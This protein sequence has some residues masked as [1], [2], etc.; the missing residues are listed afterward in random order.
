MP[1]E[2]FC[3]VLALLDQPDDAEALGEEAICT[4]RRCPARQVLASSLT[5]AAEAAIIADRLDRADLILREL[6]VLLRE[7]G[8][9][10]WVAEALELT[11]L[12]I[13]ASDPAA[14]A[15]ALGAAE[16]VRTALGEPANPGGILARRIED[17]RRRIVENRSAEDLEGALRRGGAMAIDDAI[18]SALDR[19]SLRA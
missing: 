14:A 10:R 9:R 7:L 19:L 17:C 8:A 6:L 2:D 12:V 5:R 11:A 3:L 15:L 1:S 4:A 13:G 18:G 16:A